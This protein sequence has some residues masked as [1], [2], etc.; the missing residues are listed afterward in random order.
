MAF[1]IL[2]IS[3]PEFDICRTVK[4]EQTLTIDEGIK[5]TSSSL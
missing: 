2:R 4:F 5:V 1:F 3:I